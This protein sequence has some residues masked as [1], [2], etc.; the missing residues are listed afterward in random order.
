MNIISIHPS[1]NYAAICC[2]KCVLAVDTCHPLRRLHMEGGMEQMILKLLYYSFRK[3][4]R[5]QKSVSFGWYVPQMGVGGG[6]YRAWTQLLVRTYLLS[7][8]LPFDP[9]AFKTCKN[10]INLCL[11][12]LLNSWDSSNPIKS[13][14]MYF[15]SLCLSMEKC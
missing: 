12:W 5:Q 8:L 3:G 7:F 14:H 10:S 2:L 11:D 4:W 9:E 15:M 13:V 6:V 1:K